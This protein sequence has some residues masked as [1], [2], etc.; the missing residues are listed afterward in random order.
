VHEGLPAEGQ[1][2][3]GQGTDVSR[4][5]GQEIEIFVQACIPADILAARLSGIRQ[6][7]GT[8]V[9]PPDIREGDW[10][11]FTQFVRES[12]DLELLRFVRSVEWNTEELA[13]DEVE[14]QIR[15][16]IQKKAARVSA[17]EADELYQR[18]F[19]FVFKMLSKPVL[20]SLAIEALKQELERTSTRSEDRALLTAIQMVLSSLEERVA[21]LEAQQST[22][23]DLLSNR[24]GI[25]PIQY[26]GPEVVIDVPPIVDKAVGREQVVAALMSV[27]EGS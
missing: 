12:S 6:I 9:K 1:S 26:I 22:I 24:I 13:P 2:L 16:L 19:L 8:A 4:P 27:M 23:A 20:K 10:N 14:Q 11:E 7:L 18:L 15:L 3:Q 21:S 25:A 5:V 17:Q